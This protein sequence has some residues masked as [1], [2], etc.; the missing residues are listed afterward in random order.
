MRRRKPLPPP[1][2]QTRPRP[3]PLR[4]RPSP[5]QRRR[6]PRQPLPLGMPPPRTQSRSPLLRMPLQ[7]KR[8]PRF[9]PL[10]ARRERCH[11]PG[12]SLHL[13]TRVFP[14]TPS[15]KQ[16]P[17]LFA[18][19]P[20]PS[21]SPLRLVYLDPGP[22]TWQVHAPMPPCPSISFYPSPWMSS[23]HSGQPPCLPASRGWDKRK[24][25][26]F[27]GILGILPQNPF[28]RARPG[29][30][31][32]DRERARRGTYLRLR[33]IVTDLAGRTGTE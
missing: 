10:V 26:D 5:S 17:P 8:R 13:L 16:G 6:S 32:R 20:S 4:P 21:P 15:G 9:G 12:A 31:R 28:G 27:S 33:L 1:W 29:Q 14:S 25:W 19:P 2:R 23:C 30:R 18:P 22:R 7:R 3:Q 24:C 11:P